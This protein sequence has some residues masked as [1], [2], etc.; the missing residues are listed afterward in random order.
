M[1]GYGTLLSLIALLNDIEQSNENK[2]EQ[3]KKKDTHHA[4][5]NGA[6]HLIRSNFQP[7]LYL[8]SIIE[9]TEKFTKITEE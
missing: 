8:D 9:Q 7:T 2:D 4:L 3:P 5:S 1:L 6:F